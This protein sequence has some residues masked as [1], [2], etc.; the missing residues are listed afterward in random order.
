MALPMARG[1]RGL[2]PGMEEENKGF[3][4]E[5][6]RKMKVMGPKMEEE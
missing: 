2:G 4:V 5:I 6:W 1:R 3:G